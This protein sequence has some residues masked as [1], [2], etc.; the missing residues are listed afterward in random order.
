MSPFS[1]G[2]Q[3]AFA[4]G[5]RGNA[6]SAKPLN[7]KPSPFSVNG[8][9]P[10]SYT[11]SGFNTAEGYQQLQQGRQF[12]Q[13][14]GALPPSSSQPFQWKA[15]NPTGV[16]QPSPTQSAAPVTPTYAK[17][18]A[19]ALPPAGAGGL[20]PSSQALQGIRPNSAPIVVAGPAAGAGVGAAGTVAAAGGALI[21][22]GTT[23]EALRRAGLRNGTLNDNARYPSN[24][25]QLL[26]D[27]M[28]TLKDGTAG[29]VQQLKEDLFGLFFPEDPN[30]S[31]GAAPSPT[32]APESRQVRL[33]P[34][35]TG[36]QD[37]NT[38]YNMWIYF[39]NRGSGEYPNLTRVIGAGPM[40]APVVNLTE[41]DDDEYWVEITVNTGS[42]V[43][44]VLLGG[45]PRRAVFKARPDDWM[46]VVR[47]VERLDGKPDTGGNP[48]GETAPAPSPPRASSPKFGPSPGLSPGAVPSSQGSPWGQGAPSPDGLPFAEPEPTA[49]LP[50]I[51][52]LQP[53]PTSEPGNGPNGQPEPEARL[54]P[55][56]GANPFPGR[57]PFPQGQGEP[58]TPTPKQQKQ[59]GDGCRSR[60][61]VKTQ[62]KLDG[63][64]YDM[65]RLSQNQQNIF[66][67]IGALG[68]GADLSLL[69]VINNKLGPQVPGGISGFLGTMNTFIKKAWEFTK[70]DK[71]LN[72]LNTLLLLHNAAMLSRSLVQSLGELTTQAL[73]VFG[74]KDAE[75]NPIDVNEI[76]GGSVAQIAKNVLGETLF[77]QV[78]ESWAKANNII[79]SASQ[80]VWTVRS[81]S[82]SSREITEWIAEHTGKIGNALKKWRVVGE[83]AYKWMP[84]RVTAQSR[85]EQRINKAREGVEGL[86]DAASSLSGVLGEVGNI[87]SEF[88]ELQN[89]KAAFAASVSNAT[90][91][92]RADNTPVKTAVD[93]SKEASEGKDRELGD[94]TKGDE[95]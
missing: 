89:Q 61:A 84:E 42:R 32:A 77:N 17:P 25:G 11:N 41:K 50:L 35:F 15:P 57:N 55:S 60:C 94:A 7:I 28:N 56:P 27:P 46:P 81:L 23:G 52:G 83:D 13:S 69:T 22:G 16:S 95:L 51:P 2:N 14:R 47:N 18:A 87:Q 66:N 36:G 8:N 33:P 93:E 21:V 3:A 40:G 63:L 92:E 4:D 20:Y 62:R 24:T 59:S 80:I 75:G 37:P 54:N 45:A 58:Q 29:T 34:T 91:K 38:L 70:V 49:P 43:N 90:P 26:R 10:I 76:V 72:A 78:T 64:G 79:R 74:V 73:T 88:G 67:A 19:G 12:G 30:E 82:D 85:W 6:S 68:Q 31:E 53:N 1:S 44:K 48:E 39:P 71:A 5:S 65:K 86:D 9:R